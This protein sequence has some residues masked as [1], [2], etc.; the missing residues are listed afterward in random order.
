MSVLFEIIREKP[1][2]WDFIKDQSKIAYLLEK[3]LVGITMFLKCS[4]PPA[5]FTPGEGCRPA[6]R[7]ITIPIWN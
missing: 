7:I 4:D 6:S 3:K 2:V 1:R 5:D